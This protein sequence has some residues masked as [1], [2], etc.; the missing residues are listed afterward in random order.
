MGASCSDFTDGVL[1]LL[2]D[3]GF[4]RADDVPGDNPGRQLALAE[5]AINRLAALKNLAVELA[6]LIKQ[7][8]LAGEELVKRAGEL[9]DAS[10]RIAPPYLVCDGWEHIFSGRKQ[11]LTRWV[12]D[13]RTGKMVI[14]QKRGRTWTDLPSEDVD[15]L[16]ESVRDANNVR[17]NPQDYG[18]TTEDALPAW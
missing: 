17:E 15:D 18:A 12:M 11:T 5:E 4:L 16:L 9:L 8:G 10:E 7:E 1:D 3:H 2:G 13:L 6:T 14:A